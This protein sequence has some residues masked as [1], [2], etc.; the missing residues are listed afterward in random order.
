MSP[1]PGVTALSGSYHCKSCGCGDGTRACLDG[2]APQVPTLVVMAAPSSRLG[3]RKENQ[4]RTAADEGTLSQALGPS[5]PGQVSTWCTWLDFRCP[6][7]RAGGETQD[8]PDPRQ[9]GTLG[10]AAVMT[11][12]AGFSRGMGPGTQWAVGLSQLATRPWANSTSLL[13]TL[14][15]LSCGS[16]GQE[17]SATPTG[18]LPG[19]MAGWTPR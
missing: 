11:P 12:T 5:L 6:A 18:P 9:Q 3:L 13:V 1:L 2:I 16:A 19:Q 14:P 8:G 15:R 7:N 10:L 4:I 17:S